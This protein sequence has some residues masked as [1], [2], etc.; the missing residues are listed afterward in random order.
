MS[1]TLPRVT[2]INYSQKINTEAEVIILKG[3]EISRLFVHFRI[4][5]Q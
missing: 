2:L 4:A 5:L 1:V 3:G